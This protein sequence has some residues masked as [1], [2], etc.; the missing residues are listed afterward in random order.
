MGVGVSVGGGVGVTVGVLVGA[1]V[2]VIVGVLVCVGVFVGV[3][4]SVGVSVGVLLGVGLYVGKKPTWCK[5][6]LTIEARQLNTISK[7]A[8]KTLVTKQ[9]TR[10][11]RIVTWWLCRNERVRPTR[12][13]KAERI[14][15]RTIAKNLTMV[16][17]ALNNF[18]VGAPTTN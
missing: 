16:A 9:D 5:D 3:L 6:V 17:N 7:S 2:G 4:V 12:R 1:S 10:L 15:H 18:I 14:V 8:L 13:T 11:P